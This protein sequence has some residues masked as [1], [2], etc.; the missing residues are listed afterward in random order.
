[1]RPAEIVLKTLHSLQPSARARAR[2]HERHR[3]YGWLT[4]TFSSAHMPKWIWLRW[5]SLWGLK[6]ENSDHLSPIS[7][8]FSFTFTA[9]AAALLWIW[10]LLSNVWIWRLSLPLGERC[11][12]LSSWDKLVLLFFQCWLVLFQIVICS[13]NSMT[14][15]LPTGMSICCL[16]Y[17]A[18]HLSCDFILNVWMNV[19]M[20]ICCERFFL[21]G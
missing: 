11:H 9:I 8:L 4:Q 10:R 21:K 1:M 12:H 19:L 5:R 18:L 16:P 15:A 20:W 6:C 3:H 2:T 17:V 14:F 13:M 7:V